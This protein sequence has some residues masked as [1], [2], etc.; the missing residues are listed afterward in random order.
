[1]SFHGPKQIQA[2]TGLIG[3]IQGGSK[4]W[5][6]ELLAEEY[7]G[8]EMALTKGLGGEWLPA[9]KIAAAPSYPG[10]ESAGF[11]AYQASPAGLRPL[12]TAPAND[13]RLGK[14]AAEL[15]VDAVLLI[16]HQWII[17][18]DNDGPQHGYETFYAVIVGADGQRLWDERDNVNGP[19]ASISAGGVFA[20]AAGAVVP[21][22]VKQ[23]T[24]GTV[25]LAH[26]GFLRHWK[27]GRP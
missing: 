5:G 18:S 12:D 1:V 3:A 17:V 26:D 11:E 25:L 20:Q 21:D 6:A 13:A 24:R 9:D 19:G 14:L 27:S 7:A 4:E 23:M 15:G 8:W 2:S 16:R 10:L 22:D